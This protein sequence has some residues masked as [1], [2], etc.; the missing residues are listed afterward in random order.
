M[1]RAV[2]ELGGTETNMKMLL[3]VAHDSM[4]ESLVEILRKNDVHA[5]SL[6]RKVGGAGE[7]GER[8]TP[9]GASFAYPGHNLMIF[10]VLP[11]DRAEHVISAMKEFHA[12]RLQ[13]AH[14]H[15]MPFRMFALPCEQIL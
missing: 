10:A 8:G 4:D 7:T 13:A 14:G 11:S 2:G 9:S 5:F 12:A 15:R 1:R 6:L 3:I